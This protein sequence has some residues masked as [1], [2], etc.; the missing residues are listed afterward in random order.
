MNLRLDTPVAITVFNRLDTTERVFNVIRQ[1]KPSKLLIIADGPRLD[2][3]GEAEKCEAVRGV[4]EQIDW[5][6]EVIKH[7]SNTNQGC[8]K[9][10][11]SGLNWVFDTVEEAIIL[12]H[13]TLP[14]PSFFKYCEELLDR[15]RFDSRIM[16][17][18]GQNNQFGHKRTEYSYYF[19]HF[20][21]IWGFATWRRAWKYYDIEM[22][23]WPQVRDTKLLESILGDSKA[24]KN[25]QARFDALYSNYI[26]TWDYQW[27]LSCWLQ[28]GL[29]AISEVNLVSNIGFTSDSINNTDSNSQYADIPVESINFPLKHPPHIVRQKDADYFVQ[30]SLHNPSIL[31]RAKAKLF[32]IL[33]KKTE[34]RFLLR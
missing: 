29:I 18:S 2:R 12:E 26:D 25:W 8:K 5:D 19:S 28:K 17:I 24:V 23:S 32:R 7:Y 21:S 13:D 16:G 34:F 3:P 20:P 10:V 27:T 14:H 6:C 30:N 4:F 15:Y 22:K 11:S 33:G 31:T 1:V 9:T